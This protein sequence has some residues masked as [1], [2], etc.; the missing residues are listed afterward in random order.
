MTGAIFMKF[1]RAPTTWRTLGAVTLGCMGGPIV[2]TE[3]ESPNSRGA[4]RVWTLALLLGIAILA[5]G[6]LAVSWTIP[7]QEWDAYSAGTWSVLVSQGR[8]LLPPEVDPILRQRPLVYLVQGLIWRSLGGPSMRAGRLYSLSFSVL[9]VVATWLVAQSLGRNRRRALLAAFL[10]AASPVVTEWVSSTF[11][12]IPAAALVWTGFWGLRRAA[13]SPPDSPARPFAWCLGAGIAFAGSLLAKVTAAPL[14]ALLVV[15]S[16]LTWPRA[17]SGPR[18]AMLSAPVLAPTVAVLLYFDAIRAGQPWWHF[19]AGWAGPFYSNRAGE[20]WISNLKQVRWFG[21]FLSSMLVAAAGCWLANRAGSDGRARTRTLRFVVLALLAGYL[22][23]G[24]RGLMAP[25]RP[26][27]SPAWDRWLAGLPALV[28][29]M[30]L[31]FYGARFR[32]GQRRPWGAE[33]LPASAVFALLWWWKLGY[34]RRFLVLIL[35][36]VCIFVAGWLDQLFEDG[37]E[38]HRKP[39]LA[40]M[41]VVAVA[42]F[43]EGA[44]SMDHAYPVFS[45]HMLRLNE[46]DGL[47]PESKLVDIFGD[48][49][50]VLMRL[51]EIVRAE[52]RVRVISP[53][54]RLMFFLGSNARIDYPVDERALDGFDY[55]LWTRNPGVAREYAQNHHLDR[56]LERLQEGGRLTLAFAGGEYEVYRIRKEAG[57]P[58]GPAG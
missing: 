40:G 34:N 21:V 58:K 35:P 25:I 49:A 45:A 13:L 1:G 44:R 20:F 16:A 22:F 32:S 29:V 53:D 47:R 9:L 10:V 54:N 27:D 57:P 11:T 12:D 23:V 56:P 37:P 38:R 39:L 41:L 55:L 17:E 15:T 2:I 36:A 48:N 7:F 24:T 5:A 14:V 46:K 31:A 28:A 51:Q 30:V 52:P 26:Y 18:I 6:A 43:W 50:R 19:L 8:G 42:V 3:R 4:L 33:L